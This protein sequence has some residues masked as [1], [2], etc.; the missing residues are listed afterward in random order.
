MSDREKKLLLAAGAV[1]LLLF[2]RGSLWPWW[3]DYVD[4]QAR[5]IK[6][7]DKQIVLIEDLARRQA[8]LSAQTEAAQSDTP[9]SEVDGEAAGQVDDKGGE[10]DQAVRLQPLSASEEWRQ[11]LNSFY[12][13][14]AAEQASA[15]LQREVQQAARVEGLTLTLID[16]P[17]VLEFDQF[18]MLSVRFSFSATLPQTLHL[19]ERLYEGGRRL[20]VPS[21]ELNFK[22]GGAKADVD[23]TVSG[24]QYLE[25]ED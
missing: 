25:A 13:L 12:P 17:E 1:F 9:L 21:M 22:E 24:F 8:D 20:L 11:F 6:R 5:L 16:V 2:I 3:S 18:R 19:V 14:K 7:L 4:E 23:L 15:D 10:P